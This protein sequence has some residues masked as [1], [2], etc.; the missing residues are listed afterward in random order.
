MAVGMAVVRLAVGTILGM[1][2]GDRVRMTVGVA[3]GVAVVGIA[4]RVMVGLAFGDLVVL[5]VGWP[6]AIELVLQ[7]GI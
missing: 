7:W 2:V 4:E 6:W 1:A 5:A 3:A